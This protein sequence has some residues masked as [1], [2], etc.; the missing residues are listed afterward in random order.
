MAKII[1][2]A[3][4]RDGTSEGS[5]GITRSVGH[6]ISNWFRTSGSN[7]KKGVV[8]TGVQGVTNVAGVAALSGSITTAA[9]SGSLAAAAG[10]TTV[11]AGSAATIV[12]A[13][14]L[15]PITGIVMGVVGL[16]YLGY[17]RYSNRD[18]YHKVLSQ[19]T[20]SLID[21]SPPEKQ[22]FEGGEGQ[23]EAHKA[24]D[25]LC[26]QGGNQIALMS[27]KYNT[28]A[29]K[30]E[31]WFNKATDL[32]L[33]IT[34][35]ADGIYQSNLRQDTGKQK[36]YKDQLNKKASDF[37]KH[38]AKGIVKGGAV[39]EYIRRLAHMSNYLQAHHVFSVVLLDQVDG[40]TRD[41]KTATGA[42]YF[43]D[44]V[45]AKTIRERVKARSDGLDK[46]VEH[47][48]KILEWLVEHYG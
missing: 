7:G 17:S 33:E 20:W 14:A 30:Y 28:R 44:M 8:N 31:E 40:L 36:K 18:K 34:I 47:K 23:K 27:D 3:G 2:Y 26:S 11:G 12:G 37:D 13:V 6:S 45:W 4:L 42:D 22:A 5:A 29:A 38:V 41:E 43:K 15:A 25:Q 46:M 48:T 10:L 9:T 35:L 16:G 21:D 39:W 24:A 1:K 19:Y 32:Y